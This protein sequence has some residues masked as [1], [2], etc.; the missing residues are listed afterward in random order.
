VRQQR[1]AQQVSPEGQGIDGR[2]AK[3]TPLKER[4]ASRSQT[5]LPTRG[6]REL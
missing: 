6:Q 2:R 4:T 3:I 1:A 5:K